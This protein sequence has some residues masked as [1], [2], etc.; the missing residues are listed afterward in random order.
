L[1][2]QCNGFGA[3]EHVNQAQRHQQIEVGRFE[4]NPLAALGGA[5]DLAIEVEHRWRESGSEGHFLQNGVGTIHGGAPFPLRRRQEP[6]SAAPL[7]DIG[8]GLSEEQDDQGEDREHRCHA[9]SDFAQDI[10]HQIRPS[11]AM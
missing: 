2:L 1:F 11:A 4:A 9:D 3:A 7:R 8:R 5:A 6:S 10:A